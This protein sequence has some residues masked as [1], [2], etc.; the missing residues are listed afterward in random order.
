MSGH[1]GYIEV[2]R[3]L[4]QL[5]QRMPDVAVAALELKKSAASAGTPQFRFD[6]LWYAAPQS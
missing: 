4:D 6:L 2:S 3:F 1:G 5:H